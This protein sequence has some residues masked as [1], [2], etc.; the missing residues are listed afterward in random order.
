MRPV[1]H[2]RNKQTHEAKSQPVIAPRRKTKLNFQRNSAPNRSAIAPRTIASQTMI[3]KK[4][5]RQIT[6]NAGNVREICKQKRQPDDQHAY[7]NDNPGPFQDITEAAH[8]KAKEFSFFEA[9]A[10]DPGQADG[11]EIHLD[12]DSQEVFENER[13]RIDCGR[14]SQEPG[15]RDQTTPLWQSPENNR[16]QERGQRAQQE[17]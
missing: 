11:N 8:G 16:F 12:V 7:G 1:S 9:H 10:L 15:S 4:W 5:M 13:G 14:D 2:W 17:N 3:Q 6:K